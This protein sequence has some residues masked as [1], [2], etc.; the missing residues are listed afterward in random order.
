[1]RDLRRASIA[2]AEAWADD[3]RL[4]QAARRRFLLLAALAHVPD[5]RL[6]TELESLI[7]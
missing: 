6:R 4:H 1:M 2:H 7:D 3:F 5:E